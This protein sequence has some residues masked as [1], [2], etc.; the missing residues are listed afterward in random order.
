[1]QI[2]QVW[3]IEYKTVGPEGLMGQQEPVPYLKNRLQI[4]ATFCRLPAGENAS[5]AV[6][7]QP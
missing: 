1:V 7:T 5:L 2:I 4:K 6:R 3:V